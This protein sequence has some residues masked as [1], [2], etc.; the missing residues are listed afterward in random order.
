MRIATIF[1]IGLAILCSAVGVSSQ[2]PA[3]SKTEE[4]AIRAVLDEQQVAWNKGDL[5]GF[6]RGYANL[7][8][9]TFYSGGNVTSGW[10]ATLQRYRNTYQ[11][12]GKQMGRLTFSN[13]EIHVLAP[14]AAWVGGRWQLEMPDGKKPGGLFTLIFR[15]LPEGWRIVHDHTSAQ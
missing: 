10:Q 7:P 12:G 8:E 3:K 13:L 4:A 2:S 15:K 14:D 9:L 11:N 1:T 5:D 6:M